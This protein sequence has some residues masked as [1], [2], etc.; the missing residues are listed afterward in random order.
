MVKPTTARMEPSVFRPLRVAVFTFFIPVV[1]GLVLSS[2]LT[3]REERRLYDARA[4]LERLY[5]FDRVRLTVASTIVGFATGNS[6]PPRREYAVRQIDQLIALSSDPD[7]PPKL[8]ALRVIVQKGGPDHDEIIH[9]LVLFHEVTTAEHARKTGILGELEEQSALQFR[10]E[11]AVPLGLIAIG[12]LLFPLAQRRLI[13]PLDAFGRQ[14]ARLADGDFTPAPVDDRVEPFLLPLHRQ[15]NELARRLQQLEAAHRTQEELLHAKV[16]AATGQLLDQQRSLAR[17]ERLAATGEL[18]ASVAHELRNPLAGLRMTLGNLRTELRDAEL[19]ERVDLM[20]QEVE[21]L[22]RLLND[23]LDSARHAPEPVRPVQ[24]ADL[25]DDMLTLTR[26]QLPASVRLEHGIDRS[27]VCRLPPDRLR[28]A[29]LNLILNAAG[30]LG[31]RGGVIRIDA[32]REGM[33]LRLTV[34]DDGPGFAPELLDGGIRPFFS[35]RERGTG[36]GLAMV[37]RFARDL[38]GSVELANI[39]PHGARVILVLPAEA[40]WG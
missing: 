39:A 8:R 31:E 4:Q 32:E 20:I 25:V 40:E 2:L 5:E 18:A 10:L 14:L 23:L 22:A 28:Q 26:Y 15:F 9:T 38:G 3:A 24:L 33:T 34:C 16:Q 35:T 7:T 21:R 27:L 1:M 6:D 12:A 30:A 13:R 36:L 29:L 37:R 17:A 19:T 11:L